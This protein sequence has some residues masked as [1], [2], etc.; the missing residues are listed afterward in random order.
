M[1]ILKESIPIEALLGIATLS[2]PCPIASLL[3]EVVISPYKLV[4]WSLKAMWF[5][6]IVGSITSI[7][8]KSLPV[9]ET[10]I[11]IL[12]LFLL[13]THNIYFWEYSLSLQ[14]NWWISNANISALLVWLGWAYFCRIVV[15]AIAGSV[16]YNCTNFNISQVSMVMLLLPVL[17]LSVGLILDFHFHQKQVKDPVTVNQVSQVSLI[18]F[19]GQ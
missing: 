4:S 1:H 16:F 15:P 2:I 10:T 14:D 11:C 5:I 19:Y 13:A 7:C 9:A 17:L 12:Q 6:S 3:A 8:E 18:S